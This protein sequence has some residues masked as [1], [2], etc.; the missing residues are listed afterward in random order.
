[1]VYKLLFEP[2]LKQD[3]IRLEKENPA[4]VEKVSGLI[5]NTLKNPFIGLGKPEPIK[6]NF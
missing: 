6:G 1:V 3:L 5:T 2:R 4:L